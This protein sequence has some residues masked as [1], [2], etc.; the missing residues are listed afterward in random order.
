MVSA[1]AASSASNAASSASRGLLFQLLFPVH[2]LPTPPIM[3]SVHTALADVVVAWLEPTASPDVLSVVLQLLEPPLA[4][5]GQ[6]GATFSLGALASSLA[7]RSPS[8]R[9][10]SAHW[11][12]STC[13]W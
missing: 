1:S 6:V 13:H 8:T 9:R 12:W 4:A 7:L 5:R 3:P 10:S 11:I 2:V